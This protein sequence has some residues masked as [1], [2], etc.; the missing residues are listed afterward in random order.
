MSPQDQRLPDDGGRQGRQQRR[1][2]P[3]GPQVGGGIVDCNVMIVDCNVLI[4][5]LPDTSS[6][7]PGRRST[8]S[9]G[10]MTGSLWTSRPPSLSTPA[11]GQNHVWHVVFISDSTYRQILYL[12]YFFLFGHTMPYDTHG[13]GHRGEFHLYCPRTEVKFSEMTGGAQRHESSRTI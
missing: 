7:W 4:V 6:Q 3:R 2:Q 11:A 5:T 1:D 10:A 13:G 12:P 8:S 9:T